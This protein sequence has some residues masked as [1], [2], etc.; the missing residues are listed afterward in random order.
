MK[1]FFSAIKENFLVAS[2]ESSPSPLC[3]PVL[4]TKSAHRSAVLLH[5]MRHLVVLVLPALPREEA[6]LAHVEA[7]ALQAAV[8]GRKGEGLSSLA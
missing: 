3:P 6:V 2:L 7:E 8:P 4:Y 5:W 1:W